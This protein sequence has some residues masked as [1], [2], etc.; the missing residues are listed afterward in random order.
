MIDLDHLRRWIGRSDSA[1]ERL[2]PDLIARLCATLDQP[3]PEGTAP[4]LIHLCLAPP[5]VPTAR[6]GPD[7]HPA[8]GGFLP[9]VALP[10]RMWAGGAFTFHRPLKSSDNVTRHSTIRDVVLKEGRSGPLCFV[11][12]D[13]RIETDG[14]LAIEERQDIVYRPASRPGPR[15]GDP[16]PRG[17]F[18][19]GVNGAAVVLFRYSALTFNGHRIHYDRPHTVEVEGYPGLVVHGPLQA[20]WLCQFAERIAGRAP[21]RFEFRALSPLFDGDAISINADWEG[22]E[23]ALWTAAEGGPIAMQARAFWE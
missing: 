17:A 11:T 20:T 2:S 15:R 19:E 14:A 12:V 10:N 3:T 18:H 8:R 16:A 5:V 1:Q 9:P 7:G 23:L 21:A 22:G 13:H 6:L 4:L